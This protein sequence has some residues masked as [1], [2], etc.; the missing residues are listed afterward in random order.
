[1]LTLAYENTGHFASREDPSR[2][3]GPEIRDVPVKTGRLATLVT[4]KYIYYL[5][6]TWQGD[7]NIVQACFALLFPFLCILAFSFLCVSSVFV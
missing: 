5:V 4:A 1:M 6:K 2:D 3:T 7:K